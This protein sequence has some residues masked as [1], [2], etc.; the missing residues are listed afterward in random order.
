MLSVFLSHS[1][2]DGEL[3]EA[4]ARFLRDDEGHTVFLDRHPEDGIRVGERWEDVLYRRLHIADAVVCIV[5]EHHVAS[6][7]CFAEVALAKSLGHPVLP[8]GS[9]RHPLLESVQGVDW[10]TD[11]AAARAALAIPL[12]VLAAGGG[13]APDPNRPLYPGLQHFELAD[14]AVFFGRADETRELVA[15]IRQ[16][17]TQRAATAVV[18]VGDSG[19]G[20]S[21]LVRAQRPGAGVGGCVFGDHC[22]PQ[23]FLGGGYLRLRRR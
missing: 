15:R 1:S 14:A 16:L 17:D 2:Q 12:R 13:T 21:S 18:V 5:T 3:V 22:L 9:V 11:P 23:F 10:A 6:R 7:W 4:V 20:K 19:S 8:V